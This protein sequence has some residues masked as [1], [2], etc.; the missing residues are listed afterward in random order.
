MRHRSVIP[1]FLVGLQ[2]AACESV[3]M[4]N[5]PTPGLDAG[6]GP[7][8]LRWTSVSVADLYTSAT[9]SRGRTHF[10]G[11]DSWGL[12]EDFRRFTEGRSASRVWMTTNTLCLQLTSGEIEC[13]VPVGPIVQKADPTPRLFSSVLNITCGIVG[14]G[15]LSCPYLEPGFEMMMQGSFI[16]ERV[17]DM[18][19]G[20]RHKCL[21]S[22][23]GTMTCYI[24]FM[25]EVD[26]SR[27]PTPLPR[28]EEIESGDRAVCGLI[29]GTRHIFCWERDE[30]PV[31]EAVRARRISKFWGSAQGGICVLREEDLRLSCFGSKWGTWGFQ[32]PGAEVVISTGRDVDMVDPGWTNLDGT[33]QHLCVL[34]ADG[35]L[36]CQDGDVPEAI[37]VPELV[38]D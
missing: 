6:V 19:F 30:L 38:D 22:D 18:G 5:D 25:G 10:W 26:L 14:D 33:P 29:E 32:N 16:P 11:E 12:S 20:G 28:F 34:Y 9:D 15:T 7:E 17:I 3:E 2:V 36:H 37:Q 21:L 27:S 23:L 8:G 4:N 24:G 35:E 1:V 31:P 13:L